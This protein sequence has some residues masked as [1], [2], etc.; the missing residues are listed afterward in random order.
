MFSM[1]GAKKTE[2]KGEAD[3]SFA[4]MLK[5]PLGVMMGGLTVM[6]GTGLLLRTLL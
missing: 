5:S 1:A 4:G 3:T 6:A 2:R